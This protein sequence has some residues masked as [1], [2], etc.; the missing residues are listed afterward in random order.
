MFISLTCVGPLILLVFQNV[1]RRIVRAIRQGNPMGRFLKKSDDGLW[2][3]VGDKV[4]AE[5]TS[6]GKNQP[7]YREVAFVVS[8][9]MPSV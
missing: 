5:K 7:C 9:K 4:A 2:R 3:D 8:C 1:A 6:Q